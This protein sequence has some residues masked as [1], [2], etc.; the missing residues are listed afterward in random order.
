VMA[1]IAKERFNYVNPEEV[2]AG[3]AN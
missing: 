1:S 3:R 2:R